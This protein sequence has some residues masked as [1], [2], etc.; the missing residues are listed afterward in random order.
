MLVVWTVRWDSQVPVL[1]TVGIIIYKNAATGYDTVIYYGV[2]GRRRQKQGADFEMQENVMC[3][4][5]SHEHSRV[6][7]RHL[8][9]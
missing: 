2:H 6:K 3:I 7:M 5:A 9:T 8:F 1:Y 4:Q